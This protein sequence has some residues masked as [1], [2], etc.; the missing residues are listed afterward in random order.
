MDTELLI[1]LAGIV[2]FLVLLLTAYI[3]G[4]IIENRHFRRI[5]KREADFLYLPAVTIKNAIP[6][7]ARIIRS[8][9]ATGSCVVSVDY[10]KRFLA[11]LRTI[12]GGEVSSYETLLDRAR[13]EAILRMKESVPDAFIIE[14]LRLETANVGSSINNKQTACVEVLAYGTAVFLDNN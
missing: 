7:N 12:F 4:T 8:E 9:L 13:R 3:T 10:F 1:D 6:E 11:A 2:I 14:N 5:E